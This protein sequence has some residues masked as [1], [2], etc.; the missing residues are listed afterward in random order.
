MKR[1]N[2]I[3]LTLFMS[4]LMIT[5]DCSKEEES[6]S[7]SSRNIVVLEQPSVTSFT[8]VLTGTFSGVDKIDINLGKKGVLYC[9]KSDESENLFKTWQDGS[10]NPGCMMQDEFTLTG[11]TMQCTLG[12]LSENTEYSYCMFLQKKNGSRYISSISTFKTKSFNPEIKDV[13]LKSIQCFVAFAEGEILLGK[14]DAAYC[15][16]GVVVSDRNNVTVENSSLFKYN[17]EYD[18]EFTLRL[19]GLEPNKDYYCRT[20]VKYPITQNQS[21]YLYG[22]EKAFNTK[23]FEDVAVD[24]GLP[25]G[26]LWAAYNIGAEKPEEYGDYFAWAEVEPK[27]TYNWSTY[28][29]RNSDKYNTDTTSTK[30]CSHQYIVLAD[31]AAN[32]NWGGDWRMPSH[33]E[34]EE[35]MAYCDFFLDTLNG[36]R[37]R[38]IVSRINGNAIFTPFAGHMHEATVVGAGQMW[39]VFSR[40]LFFADGPDWYW[41]WRNNEEDISKEDFEKKYIKGGRSDGL[42]VRAV[43]RQ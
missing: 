13:T 12:G 35:L 39:A 32:Y 3:I 28:K 7:V 29:W 14:R 38:M 27:T 43:Y 36:V 10:D 19:S 25:S 21:G 15:E 9:I 31:D 5:V 17:G 24:L 11:E 18:M 4:L 20:Y 23:K 33:I 1:E 30:V 6:D 41:Y 22:P 34:Q 42:T 16:M 37:G 8:A 26:T 40:D 2:I